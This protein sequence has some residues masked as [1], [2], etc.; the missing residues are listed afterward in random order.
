[1]GGEGF[2]QIGLA[3]RRSNHLSSHFFE[4]NFVD[5]FLKEYLVNITVEPFL[6]HFI[7]IL[8]RYPIFDWQ[9][10]LLFYLQSDLS[11]FFHTVH[12]CGHDAAIINVHE[13]IWMTFDNNSTMSLN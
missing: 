11:S 10:F 7:V 3:C 8:S 2:R 6:L 5:S 1:M 4:D 9:V 13:P 12:F